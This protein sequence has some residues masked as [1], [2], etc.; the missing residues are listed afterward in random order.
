MMKTNFHIF[1]HCTSAKVVWFC[2][3]TGH[4][5]D[6]FDT[7][8]YPLNIIQFM[9]Q[10]AQSKIFIDTTFTMQVFFF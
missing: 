2:T 10:A 9:L 1:F 3:S 7:T 4:R 8:I 5:T 6:D